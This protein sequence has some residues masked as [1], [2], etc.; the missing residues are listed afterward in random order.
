M[1]LNIIN[2]VALTF[3]KHCKNVGVDKQFGHK[4]KDCLPCLCHGFRNKHFNKI[5]LDS[6][7]SFIMNCTSFD[8]MHDFSINMQRKIIFRLKCKLPV[9]S[10]PVRISILITVSCDPVQVILLFVHVIVMY[11]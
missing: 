10:W 3:Q 6:M 2:D 11:E 5:S 9:S 1:T 7:L 8:K 4:F